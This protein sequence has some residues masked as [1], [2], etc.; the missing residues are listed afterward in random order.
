MP[1]LR[2]G[3]SLS[4]GHCKVLGRNFFEFFA[5]GWHWRWEV[6]QVWNS[7]SSVAQYAFDAAEMPFHYSKNDLEGERG[8]RVTAAVPPS[9]SSTAHY[10]HN[11]SNWRNFAMVS[12][13][14]RPTKETT[15]QFEAESEAR[16]RRWCTGEIVGA[17]GPRLQWLSLSHYYTLVHRYYFPLL[18]QVVRK[19]KRISST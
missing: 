6:S 12:L 3:D 15:S 17:A 7:Y 4:A 18:L 5:W 10:V 19:L 11:L 1:S 8:E 9:S 14:L 13:S 16:W 2:K